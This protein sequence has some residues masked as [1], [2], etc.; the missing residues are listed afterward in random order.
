MTIETMPTTEYEQATV[1]ALPPAAEPIVGPDGTMTN[2]PAAMEYSTTENIPT[3][4]QEITSLL[5]DLTSQT[6]D[7]FKNNRNLFT[8]LGWILLGIIG[9]RLMF[10]AVDAI[11]GL[12]L[13]DPLLKIVGLTYIVN[14]VWS[15]LIW[16]QDRQKFLEAFNRTKA[17]VLGTQN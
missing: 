2:Y 8:T 16:E 13:V 17:E 4:Q 5:S 6:I 1:E 12:P 15:N 3:L 10:A 7:F 11:D 14:F 9:L